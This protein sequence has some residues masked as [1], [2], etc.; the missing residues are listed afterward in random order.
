MMQDR[1]QF[2]EDKSWYEFDFKSRKFIL[3]DAAPKEAEESYKA[4]YAERKVADEQGITA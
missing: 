3:T 2:M 1:P 4:F